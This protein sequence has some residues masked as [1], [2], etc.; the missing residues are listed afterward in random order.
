MERLYQWLGEPQARALRE[1]LL[2]WAQRLAAR[3][4]HA[5]GW[6]GDFEDGQ[7]ALLHESGEL[8]PTLG[9]RVRQWA[10]SYRAQGIEQGIEQG[11]KQGIAQGLARER[12]LLCRQAAR[13]LGAPIAERLATLLSRIE[14]PERLAEVG[15][16]V[17]DC[18]DGAA[19]LR[20]V[21]R[22]STP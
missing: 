5:L 21:Q 15:E 12:T 10:E 6:L 7:M 18:E 20:R 8:R 16:W 19:L 2:E 4:G 11:I 17:I 1:V 3:D 14:D 9:E 13:K 22:L